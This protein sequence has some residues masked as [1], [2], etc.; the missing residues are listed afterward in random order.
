MNIIVNNKIMKNKLLIITIIAILI[1]LPFLIENQYILSIASQIFIFASMSMAWNIIGGYA[2]QISLAHAAFFAIGAYTGMLFFLKLNISP[3]LSFI[4]GIIIAC[5]FAI[6]I[7]LPSFR[8]RGIFFALATI[9]SGQIIKEL[10]IY[11]VDFTGG[12]NGL[13]IPAKYT[14]FAS[15]RWVSEIP[16]YYFFLILLIIIIL[17]IKFIVKS[18]LG[19]YLQAIREDQD[20]AESLGIKSSKIKMIALLISASMVSI[21][22]TFYGF[23]MA[24]ICPSMVASFDMSIKIVVITIIGGLGS[25]WGPVLGAFIIVPLMEMCNAFLPATWNG[26]S[27]VLYGLLLMI[28]VIFRPEGMISIFTELKHKFALKTKL[29]N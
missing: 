25:F 6:I 1:S 2:R 20:A 16:Y 4:V 21:V 23:K 11:Y 14:G 26:A 3:W 12:N 7:G 9:A 29:K 28:I 5:L 18:R 17:I 27:L 19:Y 24:Y 10:L 8:L 15:F 13:V 22:G